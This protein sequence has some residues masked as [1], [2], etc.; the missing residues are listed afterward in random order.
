MGDSWW[1]ESCKA[2][3]TLGELVIVDNQ[4]RQVA[5]LDIIAP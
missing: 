3:I 2:G 5:R 4:K 1:H